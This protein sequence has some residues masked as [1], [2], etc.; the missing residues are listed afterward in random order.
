[1]HHVWTQYDS[2]FAIQSHSVEH[3]TLPPDLYTLEY[4]QK[5]GLHCVKFENKYTLPERVYGF[6]QPNIDRILK[7]QPHVRSLGVLLTGIK[8][9]GKSVTAK[10]LCNEFI[11]QGFPIIVITHPH[12]NMPQFFASFH[13]P[14]VV[15]VD[16]YEKVFNDEE[17][18]NKLLT[19]MDGAFNTSCQRVFLLTCNN[20]YIS[21]NMLQRPSRIR[22]TIEYGNTP[23]EV[24]AEIVKD[25]LKYAQYHDECIDFISKMDIVTV[26]IVCALIDEINIHN[27][28]PS[29]FEKVFNYSKVSTCAELWTEVDGVNTCIVNNMGPFNKRGWLRYNVGH[30]VYNTNEDM[31]GTVKKVISASVAVLNVGSESAEMLQ[32]VTY[33]ESIPMNPMY[34][35]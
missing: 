1:M 35:V 19:L 31:I 23:K 22:Y 28:S 34:R 10:Q 18:R 11:K 8:G 33:R 20:R 21:D 15:F 32:T 12:E 26:D 6:D 4:S 3:K 13:Q 25:R 24:V 5:F 30:R 29:A 27:E 17:H 16:E 7:T 9:T 14:H 2:A